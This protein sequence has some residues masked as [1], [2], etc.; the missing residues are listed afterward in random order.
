[1]SEKRAQKCKLKVDCTTYPSSLTYVHPLTEALTPLPPPPS[2]F[3]TLV[4]P[5]YILDALSEMP[6]HH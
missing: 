3:H 4:L 2:R 5:Q 1:M 6:P